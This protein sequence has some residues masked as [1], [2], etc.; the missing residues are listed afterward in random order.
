[1]SLWTVKSLWLWLWKTRKLVTWTHFRIIERKKLLQTHWESRKRNQA[2]S[3][4]LQDMWQEKGQHASAQVQNNLLDLPEVVGCSFLVL[5]AQWE[6]KAN[7][8]GSCFRVTSRMPWLLNIGKS[9]AFIQSTKPLSKQTIGPTEVIST[10]VPERPLTNDNEIWK[11]L[12]T[13]TTGV[14]FLITRFE[15]AGQFLSI[16]LASFVSTPIICRKRKFF[17]CHVS[18]GEQTVSLYIV[19]VGLAYK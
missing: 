19:T 9:V 8:G 7:W 12:R 10:M 11:R 5:Y 1:M 6:A 3:E 17:S 2:V 15:G 14:P 4:A 18:N 13:R 16:V